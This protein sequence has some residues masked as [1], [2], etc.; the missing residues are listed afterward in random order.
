MSDIYSQ[1]PGYF[2]LEICDQSLVVWVHPKSYVRSLG[3]QTLGD[4]NWYDK[5]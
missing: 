2:V 5:L 1:K 3:K 4:T